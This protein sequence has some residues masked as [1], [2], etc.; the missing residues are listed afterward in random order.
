VTGTRAIDFVATWAGRSKVMSYRRA[1]VPRH[2]RLPKKW[3]R[4]DYRTRVRPQ[5]AGFAAINA[6]I[7]GER[8][9]PRPDPH[10]GVR[11]PG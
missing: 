1:G 9:G 3:P 11:D 2:Q 8:V 10:G 4:A 5:D 6:G 7:A